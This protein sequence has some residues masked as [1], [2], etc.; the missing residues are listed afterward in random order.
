MIN[1]ES[2]AYTVFSDHYSSL[3]PK[4][5]FL[6]VINGGFVLN[7]KNIYVIIYHDVKDFKIIKNHI[8]DL[9]PR[10]PTHTLM[11]LAA[12]KKNNNNN[13]QKCEKKS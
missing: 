2:V 13:F 5:N 3:S 4:N 6:F 1:F 7:A 11:V 12:R 8:R 9:S 10:P